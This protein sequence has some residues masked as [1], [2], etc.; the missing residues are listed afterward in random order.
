MATSGSYLVTDEGKPRVN[1]ETLSYP[2]LSSLCFERPLGCGV[3]GGVFLATDEDQNRVA[4]KFYDKANLPWEARKKKAEA[5][6]KTLDLLGGVSSFVDAYRI[7][8]DCPYPYIVLEYVAGRNLRE[9]LKQENGPGLEPRRRVWSQVSDALRSAHGQASFVHGDVRSEN[10][11]VDEAG[12]V[13]ILD[14]KRGRDGKKDW[15]KLWALARELFGDG[16]SHEGLLSYLD[17]LTEIDRRVRG[18]A[19]R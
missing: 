6:H 16:F 1:G 3:M 12:T 18:L 14:P 15:H 10:V 19:G 4:V 11:L 5:E 17:T 9:W 13:K 7:E 8:F 2:S